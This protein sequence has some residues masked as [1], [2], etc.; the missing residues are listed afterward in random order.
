MDEYEVALKYA[1]KQQYKSIKEAEDAQSQMRQISI[2]YKATQVAK[3]EV[4][5]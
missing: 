5:I 3:L 2:K 4:E 1:R